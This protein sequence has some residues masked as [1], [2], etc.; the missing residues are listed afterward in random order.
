MNI[1]DMFRLMVEF[2]FNFM[3]NSQVLWGDYETVPSLAIF[4]LIRPENAKYVTV[5][6]YIWNGKERMLQ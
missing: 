4:Q 3:I 2:E 5:I 1:K 6:H